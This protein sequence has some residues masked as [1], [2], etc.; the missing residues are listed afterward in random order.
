MHM[1]YTQYGLWVFTILL[2][3]LC[4]SVHLL[5][6]IMSVYRWRLTVGMSW[7]RS[8]CMMRSILSSRP[9]SRP[10]PSLVA[11]QG[12]EATS[13][14]SRAQRLG[15]AGRKARERDR[16]WSSRHPFPESSSCCHA[17]WLLVWPRRRKRRRTWRDF[18]HFYFP[19]PLLVF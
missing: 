16:A 17:L 6:V 5:G 11:Q 10:S 7:Q 19:L 15:R 8:S 18:C 9:S 12:R 13:V 4:G 1:L 3:C 2:W 14:S